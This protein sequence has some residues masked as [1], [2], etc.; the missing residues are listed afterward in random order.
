MRPKAVASSA[1]EDLFRSRLSNIINLRHELARL[2]GVIDWGMLEAAFGPLYAEVGRPGLPTRLMAGLHLLKHMFDLSDE[3]VCDRWVENPYYQH[4]CGFEYFQ[5][6]LAIDRSSLT[7]WRER[8]G[9]ASMEKLLAASITSGLTLC[10]HRFLDVSN[11][12]E[13]IG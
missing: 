7:R 9:P 4:F 6:E 10:L 8:I 2:A 5:H 1:S 3:A 11:G 13:E 12:I